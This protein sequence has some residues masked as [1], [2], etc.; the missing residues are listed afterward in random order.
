[1]G[2][3]EIPGHITLSSPRISG[4][5]LLEYEGFVLTKRYFRV[6]SNSSKA[7]EKPL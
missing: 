2:G 4:S 6:Q 3:G 5:C 7:F 1:V